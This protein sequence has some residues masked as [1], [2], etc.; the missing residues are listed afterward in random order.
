MATP[1]ADLP[2]VTTIFQ[3]DFSLSGYSCVLRNYGAGFSEIIVTGGLSGTGNPINKAWKFN[4]DCQVFE[5][6]SSMKKP[7]CWHG[8]ATA[9][10]ILAIFAGS[11]DG[12][13]TVMDSIEVLDLNND[14]G[15]HEI[16]S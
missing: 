9:G 14:S 7:R 5:Q 2:E 1:G 10:S 3:A 6:I 8:S 15:W 13:N 11:P 4:L 12:K 16:T